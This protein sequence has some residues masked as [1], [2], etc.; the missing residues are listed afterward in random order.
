MSAPR[1]PDVIVA[2]WLDDGPADLPSSICRAYDRRPDDAQSR[3]GLA[4]PRG[5]QRCPNS[6]SSPVPPRSS[7]WR[8]ARL[9]SFRLGLPAASADHAN[10]PTSPR[11]SPRRPRLAHGRAPH[12]VDPRSTDPPHRVTKVTRGVGDIVARPA[13]CIGTGKVVTMPRRDSNRL[14]AR[15]TRS[16]GPQRPASALSTPRRR[17][18]RVTD[19]EAAEGNP[20]WSPD[21]AP[22]C[23]IVE[24]RAIPALYPGRRWRRPKQLTSNDSMTTTVVVAG[25]NRSAPCRP[26]LGPVPSGRGTESRRSTDRRRGHDDDPARR[27]PVPGRLLQQSRRDELH[28]RDE[29]RRQRRPARVNRDADGAAPGPVPDGRSSPS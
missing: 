15:R 24:A 17:R 20:E 18:C 23:S 25:P 13:D 11:P 9:P 22:S 26:A 12:R 16:P 10:L 19:Q 21:D 29:R 6:S 4:C 7:R 2:T 27:R 3:A 5:G 1:D 8:S 28:L 14:V